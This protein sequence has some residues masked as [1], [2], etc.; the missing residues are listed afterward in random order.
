MVVC[1]RCCRISEIVCIPEYL[2]ALTIITVDVLLLLL[3]DPP[4]VDCVDNLYSP[5]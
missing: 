5:I 4:V 2:F 3:C 1:R